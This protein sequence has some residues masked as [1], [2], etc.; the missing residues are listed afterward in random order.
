[1]LSH[2]A[3]LAVFDLRTVVYLGGIV[4]ERHLK[5]GT[6]N[7]PGKCGTSFGFGSGNGVL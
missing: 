5:V 4:S 3:S 1:M 6:L 7:S 2:L